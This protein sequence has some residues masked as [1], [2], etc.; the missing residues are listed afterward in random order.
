[1]RVQLIV[2]SVSV[3]V[4]VDFDN[5]YDNALNAEYTI[6]QFARTGVAAVHMED[7]SLPKRCG[8]LS[9]KDIVSTSEFFKKLKQ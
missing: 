1:M 5:G 7:Q 2:D 3:P 4:I 9:G 8:H 6:K